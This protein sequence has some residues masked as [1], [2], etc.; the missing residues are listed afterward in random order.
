MYVVC[1]FAASLAEVTF[2][3][4]CLKTT[5]SKLPAVFAFALWWVVVAT[6]SNALIKNFCFAFGAYRLLAF[7]L[8]NG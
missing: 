8:C 1:A 3:A 7:Q 6:T 4:F 2:L 5:C